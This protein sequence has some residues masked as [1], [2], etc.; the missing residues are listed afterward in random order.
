VRQRSA[1]SPRTYELWRR[2][3]ERIQVFHRCHQRLF[4]LW[5]ALLTFSPSSR[6]SFLPARGSDW[7]SSPSDCE[8]ALQ[9]L[10]RAVSHSVRACA[11]IGRSR[12]GAENLV[13]EFHRVR[14]VWSGRDIR[15]STCQHSGCACQLSLLTGL[16]EHKMVPI[17]VGKLPDDIRIRS[18]R[19][20]SG[21]Q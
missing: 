4:S 10:D 17:P 9:D 12:H 5:V 1:K 18:G 6:P 15:H 7:I 11:R 20:H 8:R 16:N 14:Q 21:R 2:V 19:G 13:S 3:S